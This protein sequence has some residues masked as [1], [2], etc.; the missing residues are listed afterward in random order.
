MV[1]GKTPHEYSDHRLGDPTVSGWHNTGRSLLILALVLF[2]QMF[3]LDNTWA[4]K[5]TERSVALSQPWSG[6]GANN[7]I[8]YGL[9]SAMMKKKHV[10][11]LKGY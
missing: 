7:H 5:S 3:H 11:H 6:H 10:I 9:L 8:N 4:M 1:S 2:S